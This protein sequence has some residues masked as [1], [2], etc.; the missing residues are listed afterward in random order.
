[1]DTIVE[2]AGL[3][4]DAFVMSGL[5]VA[6]E[7]RLKMEHLYIDVSDLLTEVGSEKKI[8][9]SFDLQ[10][11]KG[12]GQDIYLSR[13]VEIDALLTNIGDR[14]LLEGNAKG[15][16]RLVCSRCL[17]EYETGFFVELKESFGHKGQCEGEEDILEFASGRIDIGPA[18]SQALLLWVPIKNLCAQDCRGLC[19]KCGANLNEAECSCVPDEIDPRLNVLKDYFSKE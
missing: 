5:K 7:A 15:E 17:S 4:S 3:S 19:P 12:R 9:K 1:M 14:L 10:M 6:P 13:P 18:V 8:E 11:L 2:M 16:V